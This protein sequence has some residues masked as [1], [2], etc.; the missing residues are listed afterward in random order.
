MFIFPPPFVSSGVAPLVL[1]DFLSP[2]GDSEWLRR[3]FVAMICCRGPK[4]TFLISCKY[5]R[6]VESGKSVRTRKAL[7]TGNI[8]GFLPDTLRKIQVQHLLPCKERQSGM[9]NIGNP[10]NPEWRLPPCCSPPF[11]VCSGQALLHQF[12]TMVPMS[13]AVT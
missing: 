3:K 7:K 6:E 5:G 12:A 2:I 4:F 8:A 10:L 11:F 13:Y 9:R 1:L